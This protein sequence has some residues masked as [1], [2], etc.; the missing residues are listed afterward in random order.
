MLFMVIEHFRDR[1]AKAVYARFRERGRMTPVGLTYVDSWIEANFAR[2]FQIMD[3]DDP[4]LLQEWVL[5]WGDLADFE[6][7]PVVR[8]KDTAEIVGRHL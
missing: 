2:C 7:V 8:S 5:S 4:R 6:I 3:C 1:D